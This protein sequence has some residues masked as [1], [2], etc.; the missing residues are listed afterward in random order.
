MSGDLFIDP[1]IRDNVFLPMVILMFLVNYLR[2]F[3]TKILNKQSNPL[4]EKPSISF[5]TLRGS[6]LEH[7]ADVSKQVQVADKDSD[8]MDVGSSFKKIKDEIKHSS[9]MM[10]AS[11]IRKNANFLPENSVKIRKSYFCT[12]DT[13]YFEK[14]V[15]FNQMAQM[16]SN[17]DMVGNMVKQNV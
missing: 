8:L 6:M 7:K 10:R 15:Q 14:K 3:M 5:K 13:G 16:M 11:R 1:K 2:F 9:A 12:K 4:L 17:P